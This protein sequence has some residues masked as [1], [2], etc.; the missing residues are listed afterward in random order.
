MCVFEAVNQPFVS[1]GISA[2]KW[3]PIRSSCGSI[4]P[5]FKAK[6]P[7]VDREPGRLVASGLGSGVPISGFR[8]G[9]WEVAHGRGQ[10]GAVGMVK[11]GIQSE[12]GGAAPNATSF[13]LKVT[14]THRPQAQ[15]QP[16][17]RPTGV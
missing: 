12:S 6:T 2:F 1:A 14:A 8:F 13:W 15:P 16:A 10:G 7:R 17:G 5:A 3:I 9:Q 4:L 11:C